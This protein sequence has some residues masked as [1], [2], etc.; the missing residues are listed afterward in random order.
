MKNMTEKSKRKPKAIVCDLDD[1]CVNFLSVLTAIHRAR[2]N[3][4]VTEND[5]TS[6]NFEEVEIKDARGN[7]VVGTELRTIFKEYENE[8]LYAAIP[9]FETAKQALNIANKLGYKVIILTARNEKYRM[10]TE[11]NLVMQGIPCDELIFD[12]DKVKRINQLK[13]RYR[14]ICFA[15]DKLET[16]QKVS[17]ECNLDYNF[18]VER[19]HNRD[20]TIPDGVT[21][22]RDLF[23]V[24]RVL[25]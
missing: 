4:S 12:A 15:D 17:E 2:H 19:P 14:V 21:K 1:V 18:V 20:L 7:V 5:L 13:R 11:L 10:P 24:I 16:V 22:I 3:S 23:E 6:W 9:A 8:G 25:K